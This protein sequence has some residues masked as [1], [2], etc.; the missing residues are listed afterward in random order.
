MMDGAGEWHYKCAFEDRLHDR[1][2]GP[3]RSGS[4]A[5]G[6]VDRLLGRFGTGRLAQVQGAPVGAA[7]GG[8]DA[9]TALLA[10]AVS[11]QGRSSPGDD[12]RLRASR[13]CEEATLRGPALLDTRPV[14]RAARKCLPNAALLKRVQ[15]VE[16][17]ERFR[18]RRALV[19]D[20]VGYP[21]HGPGEPK[22][23]ARATTR[24][25]APR[26]ETVL[27]TGQTIRDLHARDHVLGE[28]PHV[29][30]SA[31]QRVTL[32]Y[33]PSR[34][35][36]SARKRTATGNRPT[37]SSSA[38][39]SASEGGAKKS[40]RSDIEQHHVTAPVQDAEHDGLGAH[41]LVGAESPGR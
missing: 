37:A 11:A 40:A 6:V 2:A 31:A 30:P 20:S 39:R 22:H 41:R 8:G 14:L 32:P 12:A 17:A 24:R 23:L 18:L 34:S 21:E 9:H 27:E 36:M 26:R 15:C 35:R 25:A 33:R 3:S 29:A 5:Q 10:H 28:R 1:L 13:G 19:P 38:P 16:E 4:D 7:E